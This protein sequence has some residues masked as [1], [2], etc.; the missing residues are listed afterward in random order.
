MIF[1]QKINKPVVVLF[2]LLLCVLTFFAWVCAFAK[3]EGTIGNSPIAHILADL[4][5]ILAFPLVY[6]FGLIGIINEWTYLLGLLINCIFYALCLERV[7][8]LFHKSKILRT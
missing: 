4:F 6:V 3:D 2:T 7:I 5:N 1:F 8:F